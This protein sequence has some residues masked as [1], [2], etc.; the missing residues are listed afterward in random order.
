MTLSTESVPDISNQRKDMIILETLSQPGEITSAAVGHF[1]NRKQFTLVLAKQTI[2]SIFNYD[3]ESGTF[4]LLDHK[5]TFKQ[6]FSIHTVPQQHI[7]DC[8]LIITVNGEGIVVQWHENDFFPLVAG[9][10]LDA[11]LSIMEN[12]LRRRY[13]VDPTFLQ[14]IQT[15]PIHSSSSQ[16]LS[17]PSQISRSKPVNENEIT[18]TDLQPS[19]IIDADPLLSQR[20]LTRSLCFID[21][22][23]LV[24]LSYDGAGSDLMYAISQNMDETLD[25]IPQMFGWGDGYEA[26]IENGLEHIW[27]AKQKQKVNNRTKTIQENEKEKENKKEKVVI[28]QATII[29]QQS[30]N[31]AFIF[32]FSNALP[33]PPFGFCHVYV[34]DRTE[35]VQDQ[36]SDQQ[37]EQHQSPQIFQQEDQNQSQQFIHKLLLGGGKDILTIQDGQIHAQHYEN[38]CINDIEVIQPKRNKPKRD[39]QK[40]KILNSFQHTTAVI[41]STSGFPILMQIETGIIKEVDDDDDFCLPTGNIQ[42]VINI[43]PKWQNQHQIQEDRMA[44]GVAHGI[45]GTGEIQLVSVGHKLKEIIQDDWSCNE[46]TK[47]FS[48]QY[49]AG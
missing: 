8:I 34:E 29:L 7:L 28:A 49:Y 14:Y 3:A 21:E 46:N 18:D 19:D 37:K 15:I 10:Y 43:L 1:L 41:T 40:T 27:R 44:F 11:A 13:R 2:L 32:P 39:K 31:K 47:L 42:Q 9:Q 38:K 26:V 4:N 45:S 24:G 33:I 25:N 5:P 35:Q 23:V 22:S 17:K 16:Q 6:I 12:P 30:I 48:S 20:V 36:N